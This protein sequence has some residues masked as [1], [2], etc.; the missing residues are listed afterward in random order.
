MS[1][2]VNLDLIDV[3]LLYKNLSH[4]KLEDLW[5]S[6]KVKNLT[7]GDMERLVT[8]GRASLIR[9]N[10][11]CTTKVTG[12]FI[13]YDKKS[14]KLRLCTCATEVTDRSLQE[15]QSHAIWGGETR[16]KATQNLFKWG[17]SKVIIA[18]NT[19]TTLQS[20]SLEYF[21]KLINKGVKLVINKKFYEIAFTT[22]N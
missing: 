2:I 5:F 19:E 8:D 1:K 17:V 18:R 3:Q 9:D 16:E 10:T 7:P 6:K 4:R 21:Y 20:I 14:N 22:K 13:L 12:E 15:Y 11:R